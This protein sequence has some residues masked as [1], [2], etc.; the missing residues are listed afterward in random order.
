MQSDFYIKPI[1]QVPLNFFKSGLKY[2]MSLTVCLIES[3]YLQVSQ[4]RVDFF[5]NENYCWSTLSRALIGV[6][7]TMTMDLREVDRARIRVRQVRHSP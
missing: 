1:R 4:H 7:Q 2:M 6:D 3:V 5:L